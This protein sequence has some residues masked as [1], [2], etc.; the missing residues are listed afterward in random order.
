MFL[1]HVN[2]HYELDNFSSDLWNHCDGE[3]TAT[4]IAVALA[5][6]HPAL[7]RGSAGALAVATLQYLYE[8]GLLHDAR[9]ARDPRPA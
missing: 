2:Q 1:V 3:R 6:Q 4:E 8:H 5:D 7:D 9:D